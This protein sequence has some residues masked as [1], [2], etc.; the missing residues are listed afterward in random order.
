VGLGRH[1]CRGVPVFG[2]VLFCFSGWIRSTRIGSESYK[3][4]VLQI[5]E[6]G[7]ESDPVDAGQTTVLNP[8]LIVQ[9]AVLEGKNT[10]KMVGKGASIARIR[11]YTAGNVVGS[12]VAG[13]STGDFS[14]ITSALAPGQHNSK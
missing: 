3:L 2:C 8:P 12:V 6:Q 4:T 1:L 13:V 9:P 11:A 10:A 14:V 7:A 5:N